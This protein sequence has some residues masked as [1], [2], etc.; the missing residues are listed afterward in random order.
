MIVATRNYFKME[1]HKNIK[2][3]VVAVAAI[4]FAI[5]FGAVMW[6]VSGHSTS[7]ESST[8]KLVTTSAISTARVTTQAT[9]KNLFVPLS[10]VSGK[11]GSPGANSLYVERQGEI[12]YGFQG[13]ST[14]RVVGADIV[15]F[16]VS[17]SWETYAK[18]AQH[19]YVEGVVIPG[20][21]PRTFV[22]LCGLS[23][24]REVFC[25]YGKDAQ[26]VYAYTRVIG[27]ADPDTFVSLVSNNEANREDTGRSWT[28]S[29]VDASAYYEAYH[30]IDMTDMSSNVS[31]ERLSV[32]A[33]GTPIRFS[34]TDGIIAYN[35]NDAR[36]VSSMSGL[37]IGDKLYRGGTYLSDG[38][39][40]YTLY[41]ACALSATGSAVGCAEK[42]ARVG[43]VGDRPAGI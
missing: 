33:D 9:T 32:L 35:T 15:T 34:N 26:H 42:M 28:S 20:A 12:Y 27:G 3:V 36:W 24:G 29:A 38:R 23:I 25:G 6:S 1:I 10:A 30:P 43:K 4:F 8:E 11:G 31:G 14:K 2:R 22:P 16:A 37:K 39:Q 7:A 21:D 40:V 13:S 41:V 18:D 5:V 17:S 19:V